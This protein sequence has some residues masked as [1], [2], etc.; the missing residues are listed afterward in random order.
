VAIF[1]GKLER[2]HPTS[3]KYAKNPDGSK[4]RC[5]KNS[6]MFKEKGEL[7]IATGAQLG[8]YFN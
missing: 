5:G 4:I 2:S 6:Y 7:A 3:P 8:K 1:L